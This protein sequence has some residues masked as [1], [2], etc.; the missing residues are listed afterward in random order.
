[1]DSLIVKLFVY[2]VRQLGAK[3][4]KSWR[5]FHMNKGPTNYHARSTKEAIHIGWPSNGVGVWVLRITRREAVVGTRSKHVGIIYNAFDMDER[6]QIIEKLG[7]EFYP[8]PGNC[9][10]LDLA[11]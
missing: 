3:W 10:Y 5:D 7:G 4:W 8:D 9:S 1:M 6:C 11:E 2:L